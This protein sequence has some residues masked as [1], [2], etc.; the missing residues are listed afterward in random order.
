MLRLLELTSLGIFGSCTILSN[1]PSSPAFL[2][3]GSLSVIAFMVIQNYRQS[4][5]AAERDD[6]KN[7][8]LEELTTKNTSALN[9]MAQALEDRPCLGGDQ[10]L[11]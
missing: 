4:K 10:R 7:E 2:E 9:R 8:R 3:Y 1:L 11:K 6:K 5:Y